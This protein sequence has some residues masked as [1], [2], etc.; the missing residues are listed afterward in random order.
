MSS[1]CVAKHRFA[2]VSIFQRNKFP[3]LIITEITKGDVFVKNNPNLCYI[4][5]VN[6]SDIIQPEQNIQQTIHLNVSHNGYSEHCL[7]LKS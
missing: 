6:F 4:H 7:R 1:S 2:S 3:S 5:L